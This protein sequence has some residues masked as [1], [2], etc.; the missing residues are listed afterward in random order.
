ME[1]IAE[2]FFDM[3]ASLSAGRKA[4]ALICEYVLGWHRLIDESRD[5][6]GNQYNN[7]VLCRYATW[8]EL[9]KHIGAFGLPNRGKVPF[10]Y[11]C[12][13]YSTDNYDAS[14]LMQQLRI[15]VKGEMNS[16]VGGSPWLAGNL[17]Y[18]PISKSPSLELAVCKTALITEY[19][20]RLHK[21]I[22]AATQVIPWEE[23]VPRPLPL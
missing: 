20:K 9:E 21:H 10:T 14:R 22:L 2:D 18:Y 17:S 6:D 11:F 4:D 7:P 12:P 8:G 1:K 19:E 3:L 15:W 13:P 16:F 23:I 5:V